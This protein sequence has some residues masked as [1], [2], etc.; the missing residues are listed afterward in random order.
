MMS[1]DIP[2]MNKLYQGVLYGKAHGRA[3]S[4]WARTSSIL[5]AGVAVAGALSGGS[6]L[7]D[8]RIATAILGVT[9]ALLSGLNAGLRPAARSAD[10]QSAAVDYNRVRRSTERLLADREAAGM[11]DWPILRPMVEAIDEI[12]DNV[13]AKAPSV[14]PTPE[15][16]QHAHATVNLLLGGSGEGGP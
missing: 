10:H 2:V 14:K 8:F 7:G 9:T 6:A 4:R 15:E 5:L 16:R 11:T 1:F 3:E 12:L 13:E